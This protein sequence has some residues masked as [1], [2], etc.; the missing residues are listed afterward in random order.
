MLA[1]SRC[2]M[3]AKSL[4]ASP[5][6]RDFCL[7]RFLAAAHLNLHFVARLVLAQGALKVFG[8]GHKAKFNWDR[9]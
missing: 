4:R 8:T 5:A 2:T 3:P 6:E 1:I 9:V 7:D